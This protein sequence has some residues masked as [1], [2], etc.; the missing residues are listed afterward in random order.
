MMSQ[1]R[2][3]VIMILT[4]DQGYGDMSC[5]GHPVLKTPKMDRLR[6]ESLRLTDFHVTPMCAPTRGE[7]MSGVH[8]LRNGAMA[9]SLGRHL[10]NPELPTIADLFSAGGYS[11]G[12]FGKWHLGDT[13]PYRPMDRGFEEAIYHHGFG[14]TGADSYWN[15]DYLNPYYHHKNEIKQA[16]G[17][18]T[19]FWFDQAMD[20]MGRQQDAGH[21][22]FCYIP[23][24]VPHFPMWV[25]DVYKEEYAAYGENPAGFFGMIVEL[26]ENM[27]RLDEFLTQQGMMENTILVF[28]T[29]NG[30]AGGALD[31]WNAGMR[32]GKCSRYDGGHRVPCFL[33]WL[34]GDL[35]APQ[36]LE[37]PA[38]ATDIAPTLLDL[39]GVDYSAAD[40]D[41]TSLAPVL[42]GEEHDLNER[43][44]V[45]QYF[46]NSICKDDSAVIWKK[47]RL[48]YGKELYDIAADPG[49]ESDIAAE[50][51]DIVEV[52]KSFYD[53]WWAEVEPGIYAVNALTVG[54]EEEPETMLTS[55]EWENVRADGAGSVRSAA[56]GVRGGIGSWSAAGKATERR[57]GPWNLDVAKP[58][59][60][61][62][63]LRRWPAES[64]LR[65]A[66]G[67]PVFEAAYG[68]VEEGVALPITSASLY[69]EG[70]VVTQNITT[71]YD[72]ARFRLDL[73]AGRTKIQG[74]FND[75]DG[76]ALCGAYYGYVRLVN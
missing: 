14:L 66:E 74:W 29:D 46:Q 36:D 64:G 50:H 59:V 17:Y 54:A 4:D 8:C 39:C 7:L 12:I 41:G 56:E 47:W 2:P 25:D 72:H 6:E 76:N 16:E 45:V 71:E 38:R 10:L 24:N 13:Y 23:T 18:C 58:G 3:N 52:M 43:I 34:G 65:L 69:H 5:H 53:A 63:D 27:A 11:T 21:P 22:F 42:R 19:D 9:T 60:Y 55:C 68:T 1:T 20:W 49:Q 35:L 15:N 37:T 33:R 57:G 30:H 40:F 44:S 67:A 32:G 73:P 62:V 48:V 70:R 26:N 51:P 61:E 31:V 28:M 75:E